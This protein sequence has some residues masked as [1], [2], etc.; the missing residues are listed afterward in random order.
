MME[1][2]A[3][4]PGSTAT[5]GAPAPTGGGG[6]QIDPQMIVDHL[7]QVCEITLGA[8]QKD[9]ENVG[10]LLSKARISETTIRVQ[11][12]AESQAQA[13]LYIQKDLTSEDMLDVVFDRSGMC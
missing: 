11:H 1:V 4:S 2:T 3:A 10:C 6:Y 9:L 7:I 13:A 8:T 12:W 5:N